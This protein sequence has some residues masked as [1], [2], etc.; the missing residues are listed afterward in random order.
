MVYLPPMAHHFS[1]GNSALSTGIQHQ[2]ISVKVGILTGKSWRYHYPLIHLAPVVHCKW[3]VPAHL[4]PKG[5]TPN[6]SGHH[7]LK[8]LANN[9]GY[10]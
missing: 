7:L 1:T 5:E 2:D 10:L 9:S 6:A 4:T 8:A 3:Y